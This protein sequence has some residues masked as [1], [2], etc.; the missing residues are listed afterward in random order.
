ML[1]IYNKQMRRERKKKKE[2]SLPP[3]N[4]ILTDIQ[5]VLENMAIHS[6]YQILV[7]VSTK[8]LLLFALYISLFRLL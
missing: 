1:L 2:K 7:P 8:S 5:I 3:F 4:F 6:V